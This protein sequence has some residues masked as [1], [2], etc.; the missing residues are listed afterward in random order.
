[1]KKRL[2]VLM[3]KF[4]KLLLS[5]IG[6]VLTPVLYFLYDTL[7]NML[8]THPQSLPL[9]S[10]IL[11]ILIGAVLI[12]ASTLI[13]LSYKIAAFGLYWDKDG[14]AFCP[15]CKTLCSYTHDFK[16]GYG[17]FY[18]SNCKTEI[19]PTTST[20]YTLSHEQVIESLKKNYKR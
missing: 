17:I 1:M 11:L 16:H 15:S 7:L 20:G 18:C 6:I 4:P 9:V 14:N 2:F 12:E 10:W 5:S 13:I 19:I 8:T 3:I